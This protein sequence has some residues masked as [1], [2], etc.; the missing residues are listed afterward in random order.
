MLQTPFGF[1]FTFAPV[2]WITLVVIMVSLAVMGFIVIYLLKF[3]GIG[4]VIHYVSKGGT[5]KILKATET[6]KMVSAGEG[7]TFSKLSE[8]EHAAEPIIYLKRFRPKRAFLCYE[9]QPTVVSWY[10]PIK[11]DAELPT[12]TESDLG[13]IVEGSLAKGLAKALIHRIK[14]DWLVIIMAFFM[15]IMLCA[16]LYPVLLGT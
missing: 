6:E 1:W 9:G 11:E 14:R 2:T 4:T 16:V 12:F 5:M 13:S 3:A 15:G 10:A 7:Y 8:G